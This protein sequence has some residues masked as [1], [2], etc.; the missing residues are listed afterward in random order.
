LAANNLDVSL[1]S[2]AFFPLF[3]LDMVVDDMVNLQGKQPQTRTFEAGLV[4]RE[5]AAA[6]R[7]FAQRL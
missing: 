6:D 1:G 4:S 5:R 7:K 2:A 3:F